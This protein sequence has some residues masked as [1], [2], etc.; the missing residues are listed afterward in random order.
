MLPRN[1]CNIYLEFIL[2]L[3]TLFYVNAQKEC[4]VCEDVLKNVM[5]RVDSSSE[6]INEELVRK[7]LI[8]YCS[9]IAAK[10]NSKNSDEEK[11]DKMCFFIGAHKDSAA[12]IIG[13]AIK[14]LA[15]KKPPIKV[16]KDLKDAQIC[17]LKYDKPID[18][19]SLDLD[20]MRVGQLKELLRKLGDSCKGCVEKVDFVQ[21][22][23][24]LMPKKVLEK[25][26]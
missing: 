14:P 12:S 25:E 10:G 5:K 26:L 15:Y 11:I 17:S 13:D 9:E 22:I 20:K 3:I 6:K 19:D 18:W 8:D 1:Y 4:E 23:R 24:E 16:C 7:N 2:L 21:R